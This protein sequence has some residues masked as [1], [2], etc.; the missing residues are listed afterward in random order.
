MKTTAI[1]CEYNPLTNGHVMHLKRAREE[2]KADTILCVM[3]G[4]FTQ[5]GDAAIADKYL[6][7]E[8]AILHGADIVVELPTI[9]AISPADN[10]AYGAIKTISTFPDVKYISFGSECGDIEKLTKAAN[11]LYSEPKEFKAEL[12][13][14]LKTGL[15]FPQARSLALKKYAQNDDTYKDLHTLLDEPNNILG[16]AYII[17]AK[18][19]NYK[20][21]F[22]TIQR[23]GSDFNC[24]DLTGKM[25]SSSAI[26]KA[27]KDGKYKELQQNVPES[28]YNMLA[29]YWP[30]E[31]ELGSL[32]LF[33]LKSMEATELEKLYD[34]SGGIH[35]RILISAMKSTSYDDM[36]SMAKTKNFTMARLKRICL[37]A[38]F[39]IY[40]EDYEHALSTPPFA[41]ILAINAIR[42]TEILSDYFRYC[43][44]VLTRYSDISKVDKTLRPLIKLDFKA[45]GTLSVINKVNYLNK[46]MLIV[47]PLPTN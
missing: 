16:I 14:L 37:Y 31:D 40:K 27:M 47:N 38:L 34:V 2:T 10:F 42:K 43:K 45:Q 46:K 17:A 36:L 30:S 25:S 26:R 1:I 8:Q 29:Q 41:Q 11:L 39:D 13:T 5:R 44:N 32:V 24:D 7:A 33:K 35:N 20:I 12:Q 4:S 6:R 28:T 22:H 18:K 15:S 21:K 3:S 23:I 19:L 9:Y